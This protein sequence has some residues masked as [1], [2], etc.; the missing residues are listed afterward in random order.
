MWVDFKQIDFA[1]ETQTKKVFLGNKE[2]VL[3]DVTNL[4]TSAQAF[5]FIGD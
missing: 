1:K 4:F 5:D 2:A 3:G